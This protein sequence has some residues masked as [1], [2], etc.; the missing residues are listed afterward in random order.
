M[1][2]QESLFRISQLLSRFA[3]QVEILNANGEF[4]INIHAE[5]ILIGVLNVIF[6]CHLKNVN[7]EENKTYPSI[8]LRDQEKRIAIQVTSTANIEKVK[9]TLSGFIEKDLYKDYDRLYIYII[10]E[11]QKTYKQSSFD[12][13]LANK[14]VF[15]A[16]HIMDKTDL[17]KKLNTMNDIQKIDTVC[18]LLESQ[19]ADKSNEYNKW[20]IYC[21]GLCEYDQYIINLY[22]YLDIKGFSPRINNTLVKLNIDKI[23]VPLKFKFD[24]SNN[25]EDVLSKDKRCSYD[26]VSALENY[27]RIVVLGDPGSGKSTSLK[28]L[29]YTICLHRDQSSWLQSYVPVLIRA[30][31]YAKY[32]VDTGRSLSEYIIDFNNKYGLLFSQSLE[33]KELI[34]LLD[35][36]DEVNLTNQRH[37]VVDKINSFAAQYPEIKIIV[38]SR[39]VGYKEAR[40]SC[41]FFH[42][43]VEN[44][45]DDQILLFLN[46]WYLA[47]S[48]YSDKNQEKASEEASHLHRSIKHNSSVYKLAC[49][50]LLMTI[51]A[52]INFQ[53]N[54]LPEKRAQLYDIST[55]TL[56]DNWVKLRANQKN[57]I[58]REILIELLAIVAFYVHEN[59]A[60]GLI[61]EKEI[62]DILKREYSN[63]HPYLTAKELRQDINDI[64]SFLREDAGFLFEKGYSENGEPLF[65]FIHLTFQEYFAAIEFNT[66]WKEGSIKEN[67]QEYVYNPNWTEVIKLAASLFKLNE[68]GR[69]GRNSATKLISD[70]L[71]VEEILPESIR[72]LNLV[73]QILSEDVEIEFDTF[74]T[75]IDDLFNHL[76]S[77]NDNNPDFDAGFVYENCLDL[78]LSATTYRK[79]LLDRI[80]EK[81]ESDDSSIVLNRLIS[82]L[83]SASDNP[84]VHNYLLSVLKSEQVEIKACMF[85]YSVVMPVADIVKTELFQSEIVKYVNSSGFL[86]IYEGRLPTQYNCSFNETLDDEILSISLLNDDRM[87]KDLIDFYVFSWGLGDLDKLSS[88]YEMVRGIY[89]HFDLSRIEKYLAKLEQYDSL[90]L[91]KYPILQIKDVEIYKIRGKDSSYAVMHDEEIVIVDSSFKSGDFD[92]LFG[93][94]SP[95]V[96]QFCNMIMRADNT[97]SKEILIQNNEELELL[98]EYSDAIHWFS[99]IKQN[100]AK[101][102]ALS[103][104]FVGDIV[105]E[106]IMRWLKKEYLSHRGFIIF[107]NPFNIKSFEVLVKSSLLDIF[108]KIVLMKLVNPEYRDK[109]MLSMAIE[110]YNIIESKDERRECRYIISSMY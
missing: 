11:K 6:D 44:F 84:D 3:E 91:D 27:D 75:I 36:L 12:D 94:M 58:D 55:T 47:I 85:N 54:K 38:S 77:T 29:A 68:P 62:R 76:L 96:A 70:I 90:G 46:N 108:D 105:E 25:A 103:H 67:L 17:Y 95:T 19:F 18:Q 104:L 109:E 32:Y 78:I 40:L 45:S 97:E 24:F 71:E 7:Y 63:I 26:I 93:D 53:G 37:M 22:T 48:S 16:D 23:Y 59:Y 39:I 13:I 15:T 99:S 74:K 106:R 65:G 8:D 60:S 72:C 20:N 80:V 66:K 88:Y 82:I 89:P 57:N 10:T 92:R 34:L 9:H 2:Q 5:N 98:I 107:E 31:D 110:R 64:I 61:P 42:F 69:S 73:C 87:K 21:K 28:Y 79:I 33:H 41:R 101:I 81:I 30:T 1:K 14:F 35:G 56:L 102:Y 51:I 49:N 50:P 52:L 83:M 86:Q 4:S 43:E 100:I